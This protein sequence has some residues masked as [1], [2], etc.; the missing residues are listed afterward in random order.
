MS[1]VRRHWIADLVTPLLL[2]AFTFTP[3]HAGIENRPLES[4]EAGTLAPG[5]VSVTFGWAYAKER[6]GDA[7]TNLPFT[8]TYGI[9][10]AFEV[11]MEIP[12]L[13]LSTHVRNYGDVFK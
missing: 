8:L 13:F 10:K 1:D 4:D 2:V 5:T 6:N 12:F 11:G 3:V 9:T 7:E